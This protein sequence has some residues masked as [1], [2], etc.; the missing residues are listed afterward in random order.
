MLVLCWIFSYHSLAFFHLPISVCCLSSLP[1]TAGCV[2]TAHLVL[3]YNETSSMPGTQRHYNRQRVQFL[4]GLNS[5]LK[6]SGWRCYY[7]K[8]PSWLFK[9]MTFIYIFWAGT[10]VDRPSELMVTQEVPHISR[11]LEEARSLDEFSTSYKEVLNTS[12]M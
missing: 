1:W 2:S 7:L 11:C 3:L 10:P 5:S 6:I 8:S 4:K 12:N 9:Y